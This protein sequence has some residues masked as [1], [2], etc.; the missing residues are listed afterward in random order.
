LIAVGGAAPLRLIAVRG[1]FAKCAC[2][3][4]PATAISRPQRA[5]PAGNGWSQA[6]E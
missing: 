4:V 3:F 5:R 1:A 2:A 6:V